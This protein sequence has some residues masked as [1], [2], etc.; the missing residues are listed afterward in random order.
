MKEALIFAMN[1]DC[2]HLLAYPPSVKLCHQLIRYP[3]EIISIMDYTLTDLFLEV[4]CSDEEKQGNIAISVRPFNL[5]CILNIREL[6]PWD[7]DQLVTIK[8]LLIR[9]TPVIPDIKVGFFS[10]LVCNE[11][12]EV[13]IDRGRIEE[14]TRCPNRECNALNTMQLYH[15]RCT[16]SSKQVCKLQETPDMIPDGQTPYTVSLSV[17]DDLVD[18]AKPGDRIEVTGIFRSMPVRINS[19]NRAIKPVFR[20]FIDVVHFKTSD[21]SRVEKDASAVEL[22]EFLVQDLSEDH[23]ISEEEKHAILSISQR[24]DV[25]E[26]LSRSLAPSIF[27]MDDAKKGVLLQLFGG[28]HKYCGN[29]R[30]RGDI[31]ILLVGDPGVAKSQLLQY[32]HK[33]SPRGIYTSGKGSSAVGLTA[34][35]I[36]DPDTNALVLESGALVLSDG[37]VCCIDEFDKMN[38]ST[39]AILHE[40]M[41][42]QTI[43]IAKAGIITTLNAR[44]SILASANPI[45]SKFDLGLSLVENIHLPPSL[46]SRFDLLFVILD[47]PD[48]RYDRRLAQHLVSLYMDDCPDSASTDICPPSILTKYISYAK[49]GVQPEIEDSAA[50]E[51]TRLYVEMRAL[52]NDAKT[53]TAT[54]RQLESMIRLAEA[55]AKMRFSRSVQIQDVNE[56]ARLLKEAIKQGATDPKT[57]RIDMDIL[58]SGS[59]KGHLIEL[60][61][62]KQAIRN[63]INASQGS[64]LLATFL[65]NEVKKQATVSVSREDFERAL[66]DLE[67]ESLISF[68]R[69]SNIIRKLNDKLDSQPS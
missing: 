4:A 53:V 54:T 45:K 69:K 28:H 5:P 68:D 18:L 26:Y 52:G 59:T 62:L 30:Y 32:V 40:V 16:F 43:S 29:A 2:S 34:S 36:R 20:T 31:N 48:E 8:G 27:E 12:V 42:Q 11:T 19:R 58:T 51:L 49:K 33:I 24:P 10:C 66:A 50:Q 9:S 39:R 7:I 65:L 56:A 38:D 57:G 44:T 46:L 35:V 25:Y 61:K 41:E 13:E 67:N 15:N 21:P 3:H 1:L 14:P 17:Y 37:G 60:Q 6:N 22:N 55:H 64:K 47:V 23:R 63:Q